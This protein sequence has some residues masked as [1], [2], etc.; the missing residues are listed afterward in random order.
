[1]TKPQLLMT[2]CGAAGTV[3]GSCYWLRVGELQFLVDCGLFQG[4]K[5]V[6]ELNYGTFPFDPKKIDFVLLTHAHTD[7]SALVP[8]L[9][10]AGFTGP[11]YTTEGTRDL[12]SFMLPDSAHIQEFEVDQLNRRNAQRG[13]PLVEP[14]YTRADAAATMTQIRCVDYEQWV[15][16]ESGIRARFW[17]AGHILGAASI[18]LEI[19]TGLQESRILRLLFSGDLG[20]D[21][22]LFHPDP[23]APA[24]FDY[25]ICEST[26]G[27][28]KREEA[29]P[30]ARRALLRDEVLETLKN[31]G[32]LVIPAFAVERTQELLLDLAY[33]IN[34]DEIAP[35]PVFVDSPLAIKV[36]SVFAQHM[37]ELQ[38]ID[39]KNGNPFHHKSFHFTETAE[40]SKAIAR[41]S[42]GVI[43]LAGSGMC[44]AGRI[45][46][47]L[48]NH[49]WRASSTVLIVG[50]QAPG[51]LGQLLLDGAEQVRIQGEPVKV[52]ARIR[53]IDT[54]S[55]HADGDDL[56]RW[57]E[58]R[59][60]VK[61]AVFLTHGDED[62]LQ[63]FKDGLIA[64]GF[65]EDRLIIPRL[66][67]EYDLLALRRGPRRRTIPRRLEPEVLG[68]PDWHN[69]W[70][71]LTLDIREELDKAA[72]EKR[73]NV[74][75]R[76]LRRALEE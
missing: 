55:G 57:M 47:H 45:R 49:L 54:Y 17:N 56:L 23:D 6:K 18:E 71:Q 64:R 44:E 30:K 62:A 37:G 46:H 8:K 10:K 59:R 32:A 35:V 43:I 7:H 69:D 41:Y 22:K 1:M 60:P 39:G 74:I 38:D 75:L 51:T 50:Y 21:N 66:D 73:R 61:Q 68:R 70:A 33:L 12:L 3:T 19:A 48:K 25:V 11:V 42:G 36:T 72:D 5:T 58:E 15:E 26:Y 13:R 67:D 20:P 53:Q 63:A 40:E 16:V 24:N 4:S 31:N 65:A 29:S 14:I 9:V 76:R 27:G 34:H 52:R 2:F 28:R